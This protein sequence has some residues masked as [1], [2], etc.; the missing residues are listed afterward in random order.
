MRG[1]GP[2]QIESEI[3]QNAWLTCSI[4]EEIIFKT[5]VESRW[6]QTAKKMGVDPILLSLKAGHA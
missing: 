5:A 3:K 4:S 1:V 6:E 2:D